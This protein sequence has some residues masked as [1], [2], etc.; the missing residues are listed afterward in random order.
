MPFTVNDLISGIV[1]P[2]IAAMT[3]LFLLTFER[4]PQ[5]LKE[6]AASVGLLAGFLTGYQLVGLGPLKPTSHRHWLPHLILIAGLTGIAISA[7]RVRFSVKCVLTC[8]VAVGSAWLLTPTWADL[9][10]SR[11]V[12]LLTW[13]LYAAAI[14]LV[15]DNCLSRHA[16]TI[17]Q[18]R[19][20]IVI[21]GLTC[22]AASVILI[23]ADSLGFSQMALSLGGACAGVFVVTFFRKTIPLQACAPGFAIGIC[24]LMLLGKV[25]AFSP[26]PLHAYFTVPVMPLALFGLKTTDQES[27][28]TKRVLLVIAIALLLAAAAIAPTAWQVMAASE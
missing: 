22:I 17:Q 2:A 20:A 27:A 13:T 16:A 26:V 10:P 5:R 19:L 7:T 23:L 6:S 24:G 8:L 14:V 3:I 15:L 25:Y 12:I 9:V 18:Q 4:W 11:N 21:L 28:L 1:I